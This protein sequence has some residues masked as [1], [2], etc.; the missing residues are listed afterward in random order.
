MAEMG[1]GHSD[2]HVLCGARA[3]LDSNHGLPLLG[4]RDGQLRLKQYFLSWQPCL[5][6][7]IIFGDGPGQ[8]SAVKQ[9]VDAIPKL[10]ARRIFQS[11]GW[12]F[13]F[14]MDV[15]GTLPL[16]CLVHATVK[17]IARCERSRLQLS[18]TTASTYVTLLEVW[19][20]RDQKPILRT[21]LPTCTYP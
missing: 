5:R 16:G 2:D 21:F 17:F 19:E 4:F 11:G 10:K 13:F 15:I 1:P 3:E 6:C 20:L 7:D 12:S 9:E 8:N 14:L 18:N